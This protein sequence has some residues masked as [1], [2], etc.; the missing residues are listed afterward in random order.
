M[1]LSNNN[2]TEAK[3]FEPTTKELFIWEKP[4]HL[5]ETSRQNGETDFVK[6]NHL[7]EWIHPTQV[8][9]HLNAGEISLMGCFIWNETFHQDERSQLSEILFIPDLVEKNIPC[10]RDTFRPCKPA[11][12]F[13]SS[14]V[15]LCY[16][17]IFFFLFQFRITS[18]HP[19]CYIL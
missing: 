5:G 15:T 7:W 3:I 19:H 16:L 18:R 11:F 4:P 9:S 13:S 12:L 2:K 10:E 17:L 8:R 1:L 6:A 14:Y